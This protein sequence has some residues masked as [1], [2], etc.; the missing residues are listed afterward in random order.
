LRIRPLSFSANSYELYS[1]TEFRHSLSKSS[2][3]R[4]GV[5]SMPWTSMNQTGTL[6]AGTHQIKSLEGGAIGRA[7]RFP[8]AN[9]VITFF[10]QIPRYNS[11]DSIKI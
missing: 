4:L 10:A 9:P 1:E 2:R 8:R 11:A 6:P 7:L 5:M 3:L